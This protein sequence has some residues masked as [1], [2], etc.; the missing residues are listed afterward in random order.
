MKKIGSVLIT[1]VLFTAVSAVCSFKIIEESKRKWFHNG[2]ESGYAAGESDTHE[3]FVV[4][5]F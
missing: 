1:G 3:A 5:D 2:F 4:F